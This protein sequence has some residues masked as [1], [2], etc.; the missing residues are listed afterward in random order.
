MKIALVGLGIVASLFSG[1]T[2]LAQ[3][4]TRLQL[5]DASGN[6]TVIEPGALTTSRSIT[7]PDVS[8]TLFI[9]PATAG[10]G[11]PNY[12]TRFSSTQGL[13]LD[14]SMSDNGAGT[15]SRAASLTLDV[16]SLNVT[17]QTTLNSGTGG[18]Y[19][20]PTSRGRNYDALTS[21]GA[22]VVSF[23]SV[24]PVGS[25]VMYAGATVP[26]GYLDCNG[27]AVSR[28]TYADL[29]TAIGTT[30]GAGDGSSTF[31]LPDFRGRQPYGAG[32]S[33]SVGATGGSETHTLTVAQMPSHNHGGSTNTTGAHNHSG[34][35][36]SSGGSHSHTIVAYKTGT[37]TDGIP[38]NAN[39]STDS[40]RNTTSTSG[41]H[42][43]TLSLSSDGDHAHT[44]SSQ[45]GDGSHPILDPY[46]AVRFIIKY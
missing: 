15:L 37:G 1:A 11:T 19:S 45:G 32:G 21:D 30:F 24:P 41:S 31:N 22:G 14:G 42:S 44:I 28:T 46:L 33:Y 12:L 13:L 29:F 25:I 10:A 34:S 26:S 7:V 9:V 43:H 18:S 2:V 39:T 6:T 5:T 38:S 27:Q 4:E 20:L 8:G 40:Y 36:T 3:N 17:G 23:N 16:T 35:S